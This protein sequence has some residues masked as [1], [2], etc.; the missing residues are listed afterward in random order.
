MLMESVESKEDS[1]VINLDA[2]NDLIQMDIPKSDGHKAP[3]ITEITKMLVDL[4]LE[5][6]P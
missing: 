4:M 5:T 3:G 6:V 2:P 1:Y